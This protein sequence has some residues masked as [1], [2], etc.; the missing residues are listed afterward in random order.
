MHDSLIS[1]TGRLFVRLFHPLTCHRAW[2]GGSLNGRVYCTLRFTWRLLVLR[3]ATI[4][5]LI[6]MVTFLYQKIHG[7]ADL[8][9]QQTLQSQAAAYRD[10]PA[11][12][13]M[14]MRGCLAD[15]AVSQVSSV[16]PLPAAKDSDIP[17]FCE[18]HRVAVSIERVAQRDIAIVT[19]LYTILVILSFIWMALS[20]QVLPVA[21]ARKNEYGRVG[22]GRAVRVGD[23]ILIITPGGEYHAMRV[24]NEGHRTSD[25]HG[26]SGGRNE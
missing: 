19:G 10:A 2:C 22:C 9:W 7:T 18:P 26:A 16:S 23:D 24:D 14:Q 5:G 21:T 20:R 25:G 3:P 6:L 13:V 11:G 1:R 8:F 12:S 4:A 15:N 17:H